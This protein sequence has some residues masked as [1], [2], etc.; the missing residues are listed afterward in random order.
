MPYFF[1]I[2]FNHFVLHLPQKT[3]FLIVKLVHPLAVTPANMCHISP[4]LNMLT[5]TSVIR[6]LPTVV[7]FTDFITA[8]SLIFSQKDEKLTCIS[9]AFVQ[10]KGNKLK[11]TTVFSVV[12]LYFLPV[13]LIGLCNILFQHFSFSVRCCTP[14]KAKDCFRNLTS[15]RPNEKFSYGRET[16]PMP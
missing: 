5:F 9:L 15:V 13:S 16:S 14:S 8:C 11:L 10:I 3:N 6:F 4:S 1:L 12:A 2:D 7:P